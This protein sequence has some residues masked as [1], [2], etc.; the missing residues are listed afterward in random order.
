MHRDR[1]QERERERE[2]KRNLRAVTEITAGAGL[3]LVHAHQSTF[4][5]RSTE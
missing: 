4:T 1:C 5:D 2:I 3:A